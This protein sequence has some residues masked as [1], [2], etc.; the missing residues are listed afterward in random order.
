MSRIEDHRYRCDKCSRSHTANDM[1][2]CPGCHLVCRH[3][4]LDNM[5]IIIDC[6]KCNNARR[7]QII[8]HINSDKTWWFLNRTS[9]ISRSKLR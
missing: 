9:K 8:S 7:Q 1:F 4:L 6:P 5:G 3:C 2:F